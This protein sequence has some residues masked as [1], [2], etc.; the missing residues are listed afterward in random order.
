M[1][2]NIPKKIRQ[3]KEYVILQICI[4]TEDNDNLKEYKGFGIIN[5]ITQQRD[6]WGKALN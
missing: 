5:K 6:A 1:I 4:E 2:Q 3:L